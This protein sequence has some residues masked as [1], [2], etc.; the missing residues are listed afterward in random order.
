MYR[1][2]R[3]VEFNLLKDRGTKYGLESGR[4][5]E[6]VLAS[7]PPLA[8]WEYNFYPEK[9]S[10]EEK[11]TKYFLKPRDWLERTDSKGNP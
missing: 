7:M 8:K 2:G 6:S 5:V 11:L 4:R 10:A 3:D 1:R 9:G